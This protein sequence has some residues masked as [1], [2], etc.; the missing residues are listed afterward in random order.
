MGGGL[1]KIEGRKMEGWILGE[2]MHCEALGIGL[3]HIFMADLRFRVSQWLSASLMRGYAAAACHR[4]ANVLSSVSSKQ[5]SNPYGLFLQS[6][7]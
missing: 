4:A 6:I 7:I 2:L 3:L 5:H 1:V